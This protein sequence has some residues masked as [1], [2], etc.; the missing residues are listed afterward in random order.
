MKPLTIQQARQLLGAKPLNV[1]GTD[2]PMIHEVCIDTRMMRRGSLFVA[3]RGERHNGND[4]LDAAIAGGAVAAVVDQLPAKIPADIPVLLT[5]DGRRALAKLT[6]HA[7][8]QMT[9]R[10]V[11]VAGSNGKTS[12][13]HLIH[14]ALGGKLN[15]SISPRS[16]NN[17]IGVP[18]TILP[19]NPNQ[20]YLVLELGTNHPGEI[21]VLTEMAMPDVGVITNCTAEHLEGLGDLIGVRRENASLIEGMDPNTGM[22]I[23][24]GDDPQV[25]ESVAPFRGRRVTFGSQSGN[26][27]FATEVK[28]DRQGTRFALNGRREVFV[29]MLGRHAA[30]NALAA[31]AVGRRL[32]VSED[33]IVQ[34]LSRSTGPDMRMQWLTV[35][36]VSL[37]NDAYNANPASMRAALETIA[38]LE[39]SGRR[40][41]FLGEMRELGDSSER[42]HR[43]VGQFAAAC[44]LD[45][46]ICVGEQAAWIA[47]EARAAGMA[48]SITH[49]ADAATAAQQASGYV[50]EGDLVLLKGSRAVHL[51]RIAEALA[52]G[53]ASPALRAA[54]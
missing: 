46:L 39:T 16:F 24:N 51:E 29:P 52:S 38:A 28:V 53:G 33:L 8:R 32:G 49:V 20:D 1:I 42:F 26:D 23:V 40:I 5:P 25:L 2:C 14:A 10:V 11:A 36:G 4:F 27:L 12:T 31:I 19:A 21:K 43:Q 13:K 37:I 15:G 50:R 30:I 7:R 48:G 22:L 45:A 6:R 54:S 47:A 34:G 3:I 35:N 44:R 17:D 41:A 9:A 18:L